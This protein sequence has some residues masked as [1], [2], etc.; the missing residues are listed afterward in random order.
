M[1]IHRQMGIAEISKFIVRGLGKNL[2]A[3][4][5]DAAGEIQRIVGVTDKSLKTDWQSKKAEVQN[6]IHSAVN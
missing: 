1:L 3:G 5:P 2:Y 6:Q 4:L